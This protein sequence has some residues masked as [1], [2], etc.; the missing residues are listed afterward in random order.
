M[1]LSAIAQ[2]TV[3]DWRFHSSFIGDSLQAVAEGNRWV[4]YLTACKLFPTKNIQDKDT[5]YTTTPFGYLFRLDK[6][7]QENEALSNLN[8]LSDMTISQAYYNSERDYLVVIYSNSNI[9]IILSDGTVVNMPELKDAVMTQSKTIN[10]VTF[11]PGLIYMATDF[12]Y[13]VIDD[14]KFVV[15]ESHSYGNKLITAAQVG[16]WLM[17]STKDSLYYGHANEYHELLSSFQTLP[18]PDPDCRIRPISDTRFFHLTG[19]TSFYEF[20]PTEDGKLRI[21]NGGHFK[22][23]KTTQLQAMPGGYLLNIP[24][25]KKCFKIDA[26]G[27]QITDSI[28][29]GGELCSANPQGDGTLWAAGPKGLHQLGIENYYRPNALSYASPHWMAYNKDKGLLYVSSPSAN[30][31]VVSAAPT[32]INTY[33]GMTWRDVTPEGAPTQGSYWIEFLPDDP[34]TYFLGTWKEGLLKVYK[35]EIVLKYDTTNSPIKE[36]DGSMHPI[37]SI[38]RKGN[39]WVVQPWENPEHP[40]MVLPAA[41]TRLDQTTAEDWIIPDL[42]DLISGEGQRSCFLST[43]RNSQ[44]IK[45]FTTGGFN[46]PLVLWKTDGVISVNPDKISYPSLTDQDG[47]QISWTNIMCL[48]EDLNGNVWMGHSEGIC[49]FNPAQAFSERNFSAVRPKVPRNDGTGY[50]DRLMDGIQVNDVAVDGANRKW[51]ATNSSGLFLVKA[52]GSEIIR[53]FNTTNSPLASNTV[54]RVCCNPTNN[55][56]YITTPEGLYEYF[57]DSSPAEATYDNLFAYPNPVRP[58]FGGEVTIT[59]MMEGSLIKIAD[60]SGNVIRQLKSTG[61]MATWDL[62]N[63]SGE[64]V[65]TG[66]YLV[67]CSQSNTSGNAAVTKIAVIR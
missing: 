48:T 21:S 65:K 6:D 14:N 17:L 64:L 32:Y 63:E 4:Y 22:K 40:V 9:D 35:D 62:C 7:T 1:A 5:I 56:V 49:V 61:G 67:L 36:L 10:D 2:H 29:S 26:Q 53:K 66:V 43:K 12:G 47:E 44:D 8:D 33:D 37:T 51:I 57:S 52:D 39:L 58:D 34:D 45:L 46:K 13:M 19:W 24:S 55:S 41:K 50:A 11:A 23:E 27:S 38:D 42:G 28:E 18:K 3:G 25:L 30:A 60:A 16:D 31:H 20:K 54:Y 15:K 59:G